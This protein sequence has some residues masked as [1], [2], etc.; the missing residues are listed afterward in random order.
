[1]GAALLLEFTPRR[2]GF[3]A[4]PVHFGVIFDGPHV[5][6]LSLAFGRRGRVLGLQATPQGAG[7]LIELGC[8]DCQ[9]V[10]LGGEVGELVCLLLEQ[11][12]PIGEARVQR[13]CHLARPALGRLAVATAA[14]ACSRSAASWVRSWAS[15]A[16]VSA[17]AVWASAVP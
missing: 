6:S 2:L 12:L 8:A 1:M 3:L 17:I 15:C 9:G 5:L 11:L 10:P 14:C 7:D 4:R 13:R 16:A